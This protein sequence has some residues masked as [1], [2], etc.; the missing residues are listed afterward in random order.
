MVKISVIVPVYNVEKY[1]GACLSS[2]VRQTFKNYEVIVI[3]DGSLDNCEEIINYYKKKYPKI[4]K[5]CSFENQGISKTRNY[6]IE[7][8]GGE[9]ITFIDS[10]DYVEVTF[11]EEMYKAIIDNDSDVCVCDYY[12]VN[13]KEDITEFRIE[14]FLPTSIKENP[15]LLWKINSGPSNKLYK[16]E[17]FKHMKFEDI[18]YEDLLL[19]PKVLCEAKRIVKLNRCLNYYR[20]RENSETTVIDKRVF[21]ILKILDNLNCYFKE[22]KLDEECYQEIEYFNIYRVL[23]YVIQQRYQRKKE[24]K[25]EFIDAAFLYLNSNFPNWKKNIYYKRRNKLKKLIESNKF[26]AKVYVNLYR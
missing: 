17:L 13:A 8:A 2:L 9:Y 7:V 26:L 19:I 1:L 6:G 16:K 5:N 4:I 3:N 11:L 20:I 22:K 23:M 12:I 18:K 14:K 10:D 21:D 25:N 24:I 15:Q